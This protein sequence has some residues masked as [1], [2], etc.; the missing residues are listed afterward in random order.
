MTKRLVTINLTLLMLFILPSGCMMFQ[1]L[2]IQDIKADKYFY[3]SYTLYMK[4]LTTYCFFYGICHSF[5]KN[6]LGL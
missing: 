2:N 6:Q 3:K 1:R 5:V 4:I